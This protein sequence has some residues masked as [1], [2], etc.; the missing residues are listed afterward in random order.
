MDNYQRRTILIGSSIYI[1]PNFARVFA[2]PCAG[3]TK[4]ENWSKALDDELYGV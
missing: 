2:K 3:I 4:Q 1:I